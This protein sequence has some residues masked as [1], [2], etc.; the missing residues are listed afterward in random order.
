MSLSAFEL[1]WRLETMSRLGVSAFLTI[2]VFF[3]GLTSLIVPRLK[4]KPLTG[5]V[6][7]SV[8]MTFLGLFFPSR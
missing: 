1:I 3:L 4:N 6:F 5:T 2:A 7:F 8:T